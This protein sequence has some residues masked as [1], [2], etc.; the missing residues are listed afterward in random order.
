M[1]SLC[2]KGKKTG[3]SWSS[4]GNKVMT[5]HSISKNSGYLRQFWTHYYHQK[6]LYNGEFS[7]WYVHLLLVSNSTHTTAV[8]VTGA[9]N[10]WPTKCLHVRFFLG[11]S[12]TSKEDVLSKTP[13]L[14]KLKKTDCT[15]ACISKLF[16]VLHA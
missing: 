9:F 16:S 8:K 10:Y 13:T 4:F 1:I 3:G 5:D 15:W 7:L 6:I 14:Q 2:Q 11:T 12:E